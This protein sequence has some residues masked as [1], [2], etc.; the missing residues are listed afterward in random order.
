M[1]PKIIHYCWFG[2]GLMPKSQKD[3][4]RG[5]KR[6]MPDYKFMRWDESTFPLED[7]PIAKC[8]CQAKRYAL[9]SDVCRYNVLAK[10]GGVYL[11]T[12]VELFQRLDKFLDCSLFTAIELYYEFQE[13]HI[14]E[15]YLNDDGTAKD[16]TKDVPRLEILTSIIGCLS[17]QKIICEIRDYYNSVEATFERA[18]NYREWVNNDRLVARCLS[19]YGFRYVNET[20]HLEGDMVI[21]GTGIFGH[22]YCPDKRY[23]VS[24][25]HNAASWESEK[26]STTKR[27]EV[28]FDKLGLLK[29]YHVY[30]IIKLKVKSSLIKPK[31]GEVWCLHR[32]L[33]QRSEYKSNRELE[34]SPEF[35]QELIASKRENGF[36]FVSID[37][38][39][40]NTSRFRRKFINISFDDGFRDVYEYAFPILKKEKIPFTLFLTTGM[41]NGTA[42]L[43]WL[44][45]EQLATNNELFEV[46]LQDI[47]GS[48]KNMCEY[49]C[50]KYN[51]EPDLLITK[52]ESLTWE[53]IREMVD[54]GLCT[55]GCHSDSHSA[56]TRLSDDEVLND[57]HKSKAIIKQNLGVETTLFSY[58]HSME[59]A[60]IQKLVKQADFACAFMGYGGSIRKGDNR[61]HLNRKNIVQP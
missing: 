19:K 25:H 5:W 52:R 15:R 36:S 38:I 6:L 3:C 61:Y 26:W 58:P 46:A 50:S 54:S 2:H 12:D 59:N 33:P 27:H 8:A 11:D 10:Y 48:G 20:Q 13:E 45:L 21:Y 31:Q 18:Y 37:E 29:P 44:Q 17:G 28:F 51:A 34:I 7:Y 9:A 23:E 39:L 22:A 43:W 41:P 57:L 4:I 47:F 32:V 24:F 40:A 16:P 53:Q 1:I 55:I 14:K 42:H 56:L 35:L 30:K 60:K 49:F